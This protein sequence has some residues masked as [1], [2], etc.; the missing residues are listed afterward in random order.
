[1][2]CRLP[3]RIGPADNDEF[4]AVET[5]GLEPGAS[6]RF[7]QF[8]VE[9]VLAGNRQWKGNGGM[10]VGSVITAAGQD[11]TGIELGV[12]RYPSNLISCSQSLLVRRPLD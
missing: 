12:M 7:A 4:I 9:G 11:A 8:A 10:F 5:F 6:V 3:L 1:M 2:R